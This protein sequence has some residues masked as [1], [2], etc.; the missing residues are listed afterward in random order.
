MRQG[1]WSLPATIRAMAFCLLAS[2]ATAPTAVYAQAPIVS[3]FA[4]AFYDSESNFYGWLSHI[5]G[6]QV[7]DLQPY[8]ALGGT[9]YYFPGNGATLFS[10]QLGGTNDGFGMLNVGVQRRAWL[11]DSIL[12]AGLW[13]D[14]NES[15]L[16]NVYQQGALSLELF[17]D[18]N[19]TIR[20]NGFLPVGTRTR[21][22][23]DVAS[24]SN[25]AFQG[26]HTVEPEPASAITA[27]R[28]LVEVDRA[29]EGQPPF[30]VVGIL[31]VLRRESLHG[32]H[33]NTAYIVV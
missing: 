16:G 10:G 5:D 7:G 13:Y 25:I 20:G 12:G 30:R 27:E 18:N 8:T 32:L 28:T 19:W 31:R 14:I 1:G 26:K 29:L 33:L 2:L 11:G 9:K 23:L 4:N 22:I 24:F 17:I 6:R 21:N 3:T 15:R